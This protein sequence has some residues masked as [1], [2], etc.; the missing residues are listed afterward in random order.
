MIAG[1]QERHDSRVSATSN[2]DDEEEEGE[3]EDVAEAET[4][5]EI[6]EDETKARTSTKR[7]GKF[8]PT[9]ASIQ[10]ICSQIRRHD[11]SFLFPDVF[12][13]VP[14]RH[15]LKCLKVVWKM[16]FSLSDNCDVIVPPDVTNLPPVR[17]QTPGATEVRAFQPICLSNSS[18]GMAAE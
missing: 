15:T 9:Q 13:N 17:K 6:A 11:L 16:T 14:K 2:V 5:G 7:K 1:R 4:Q 8:V 10:R 12:P 18:Q 3:M